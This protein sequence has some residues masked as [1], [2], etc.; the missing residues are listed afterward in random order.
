MDI[1]DIRTGNIS[2]TVAN[3]SDNNS[4]ICIIDKSILI[5]FTN[6]TWIY[7][8]ELEGY[9]IILSLHVDK[10]NYIEDKRDH[11]MSTV[12][13]YTTIY[14]LHDLRVNKYSFVRQLL[15]KLYKEIH[16]K[17]NIVEIPETQKTEFDNKIIY[18]Y[19]DIW[20]SMMK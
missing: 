20:H 18:D 14:Q 7:T 17:C 13:N 16:N 2:Y 15:D 3:N 19:I 5:D 11:I 6:Y 12:Q 1:I 8:I 4:D 10:D 9:D